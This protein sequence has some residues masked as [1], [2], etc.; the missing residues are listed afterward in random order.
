MYAY[1]YYDG[2]F[3][4]KYIHKLESLIYSNRFDFVLFHN[5]QNAG[6][7]QLFAD[8]DKSYGNYL[9]DVDGNVLL[10]IYTQISSI[11]LGYNHPELLKVFHDE[12]NLK[13]EFISIIIKTQLL[14]ISFVCSIGESSSTWCISR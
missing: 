4:I 2:T 10:D 6:A 13:S 3:S 1:V 7:V 8:Y 9:V 14:I 11:P 12:H 5:K